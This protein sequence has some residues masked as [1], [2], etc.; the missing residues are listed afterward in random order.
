V[1]YAST[2]K[3][4]PA[5]YRMSYHNMNETL[6]QQAKT[7]LAPTQKAPLNI[8][9]LD[10]DED[11]LILSKRHL[12]RHGS[13]HI[14][15]T[16]SAKEAKTM[17]IQKQ[18]DVIISDYQMPEKTGLDFLKELRADGNDVPFILF[19]G[20]NRKEVAIEALNLG[21]DR[22]FNKNENPETLYVE[23]AYSLK[24]AVNAKRAEEA[25]N[26]SEEK[27]RN[28]VEQAS[29]LIITID[30]MGFI[31]ACNTAFERE[32]GYSKSEILGKTF[33]ET[34]FAQG[35]GTDY[36]KTIFNEAIRGKRQKQI[37][38]EWFCKNGNPHV[39]EIQINLNKKGAQI[40]GLTAI[41]RDITERKIAWTSLEETMN[42]LVMINEKLGVVSRMT[43]HDA[44]N[45]LFV[46]LNNIYLAT[47]TLSEDHVAVGY[48]KNIEST[49]E[50][51]E[52]IFEFAGTY[53][54]LGAEELSYANAEKS[55][56]EAVLL[57][58]TL[59]GVKLLN[60]CHG[61]TVLADSLLRQLFY[62]LIHNSLKYG[63]KLSQIRICYKEADDQLVLVY[64]DDGV[65][66]P[67]GE[68]ERIFKEG[69]GNGT[70]YGLYLIRKIC[71]AY[72][73]TI[74]ETGVPGKGAQFTITIPKT[75]KNGKPSYLVDE[76]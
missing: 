56:N 12:E 36:A 38:I 6:P 17:I 37:E 63:E 48:L 19:T 64:E 21:A 7:V 45:K 9:H 14:E 58:S 42:E 76:R 52:K 24:K 71:E 11:F 39:S 65:G 53:E 35:M 68:K 29:D 40:L 20:E 22:Y 51:L 32:T 57:F 31:T 59:N 33:L 62:N 72:G 27:Y 69:Y 15:N 34:P 50:K 44:R 16:L 43:R 2:A 47:Q 8:L 73:W 18:Y 10:D 13:F 75:S 66:I 60:E 55:V 70:G 30:N 26:E 61:L 41:A 49:V 4:T 67:E 54:M 3:D 1:E 28:M 5:N 23:L 25:L 46:I 74:Q